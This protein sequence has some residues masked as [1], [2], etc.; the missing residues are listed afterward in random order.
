[1]ALMV[2]GIA[3]S[4]IAKNERTVTPINPEILPEFC[5][6]ISFLNLPEQSGL[7]GDTGMGTLDMWS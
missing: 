3:I 5:I 7:L 6:Q 1:D 4:K 2:S